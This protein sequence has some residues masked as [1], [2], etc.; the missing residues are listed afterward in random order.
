MPDILA[1]PPGKF[2]FW[3]SIF[4]LVSL[5]ALYF[6]FRNLGRARII[7]DTPTSRIRSAHQGYVELNGEAAAMRGEPILSPLTKTPCCWFRYKI[8]RKGDKGWRQVKSGKSDGLFLLRDDTGECIIDPDGA[9]VSPREKNVWYGSSSFPSSTPRTSAGNSGMDGILGLNVSFSGFGGNYRYT[10]E[11]IYPGEPLYAIGLF[12]SFG[13]AEHL[14]MREELIKERLSQWKADHAILL[15]RFDRDGD[16]KIDLVEWEVARRTAKREVTKEQL[17]EDHQS[18]HTLSQTHSRRRPFLISVHQEF[19]LVK[20]Y[21]Y[22]SAASI[23]GFFI[24]GC[25]AAWMLSVRL[26]A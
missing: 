6:A 24:F 4:C 3:T 8:E 2:W 21:R 18:T 7:E 25:V 26:A 23:S 14:A 16:G 19:D 11:S 17:Q 20:R 22:F 12:K 10:E 5:A 13:E 1:I 9:E 15:K